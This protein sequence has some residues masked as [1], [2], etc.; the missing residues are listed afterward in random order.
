[1]QPSSE[2]G[3][4]RKERTESVWAGAGAAGRVRRCRALLPGNE[5]APHT[6]TLTCGP[7]ETAAS[8]GQCVRLGRG[9]TPPRLLFINVVPRR[10]GEVKR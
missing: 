1:M 9:V 6:P 10:V 5:Q 3:D 2:G 4:R 7:A 8:E